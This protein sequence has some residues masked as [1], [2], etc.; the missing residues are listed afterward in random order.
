MPEL[1]QPK[2][3]RIGTAKWRRPRWN[4]PI[5]SHQRR[6]VA[7][8]DSTAAT[9]PR[10]GIRKL[11]VR[12][13][14]PNPAEAPAAPPRPRLREPAGFWHEFRSFAGRGHIER[15]GKEGP[16]LWTIFVILLILWLLGLVSGYALG[17]FIHVLLVA[18][19]VLLIINLVSGRRVA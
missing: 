6:R 16:M 19:L 2:L 3:R 12:V 18:A 5:S 17:G 4:R 10:P 13:P 9:A 7:A 11:L 1:C 15:L 14:R 8:T